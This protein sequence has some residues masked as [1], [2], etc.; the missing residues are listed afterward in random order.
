[1]HN[2]IESHKIFPFV[3][4]GVFILFSIFTIYLAME[5]QATAAYLDAKTQESVTALN[6]A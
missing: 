1:M 5:L 3:A 6:N 2:T 4:W